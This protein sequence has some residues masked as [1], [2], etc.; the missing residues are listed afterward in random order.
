MVVGVGGLGC[1]SSAY[2]A[3]AGVG[4]L[5]LVDG[6][7]VAR[8]NL[9]RQVLYSDA[10]VGRAKVEAAAER[11]RAMNPAIEVE[12]ICAFADR[13]NFASMLEG[14]DVVVDGTDSLGARRLLNRALV[15][16]GKPVI[17]TSC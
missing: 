1:A 4:S 8:S 15:T 16:L 5:R 13:T 17:V 11:L 10:D 2:L 7:S 6:D 14:V 9:G 3:M 12:G